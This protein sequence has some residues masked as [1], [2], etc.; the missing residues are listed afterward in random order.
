MI[1]SAKPFSIQP[2]KSEDYQ[3]TF[4]DLLPPEK[5][6]RIVGESEDSARASEPETIEIG[7]GTDNHI[8]VVDDDP[9][10]RALVESVVTG[11]GFEVHT[12]GDGEE[13]W[14]A[15]CRLKYALLITDHEMPRLKGLDLIERLRAVSEAPPCILISGSLPKAEW[16]LREVVRPG[17]FLPK[18][19]TIPE[20]LGT[21]FRLLGQR[22][23]S[24]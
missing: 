24:F 11:A 5:R 12:A 10:H 1:C 22:T 13:A 23:E 21:I 8:L 3:S 6:A 7:A 15:L 20:L 17:A 2:E 19:F 9:T 14:E 16:I 18:P 4:D